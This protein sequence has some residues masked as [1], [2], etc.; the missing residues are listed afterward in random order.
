M[1][2]H[3][4]TFGPKIRSNFARFDILHGIDEGK[5]PEWHRLDIIAE[6]RKREWLEK[7]AQ[8]KFETEL[9][10]ALANLL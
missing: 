7:Q 5:Q 1:R 9:D 2:T 4:K 6:G 3:M 8:K 10:N